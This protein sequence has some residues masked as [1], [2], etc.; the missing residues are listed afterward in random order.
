[1]RLH[2]LKPLATLVMLPVLM[3]RSEAAA[4]RGQDSSTAQLAAPPTSL[5]F[6]LRQDDWGTF[7]HFSRDT[8]I[9]IQAKPGDG[10]GKP[11]PGIDP[12]SPP[13]TLVE[14]LGKDRARV[15]VSKYLVCK[16]SGDRDSGVPVLLK[17]GDKLTAWTLSWDAGTNYT[18]RISDLD[19][20]PVVTAD[21]PALVAAIAAHAS[22]TKDDQLT[23]LRTLVIFHASDR[24][25]GDLQRALPNCK[26]ENFHVT[27]AE[28][29]QN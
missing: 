14:I 10:I 9:E 4:P 7:P 22:V 19:Q 20:M 24:N 26:I 23:Q 11:I 6:E 1:M 8:M 3:V 16:Q 2:R 15:R 18:L 25:F 29:N 28:V 5:I 12:D 13:C 17:F 27:S 21:S